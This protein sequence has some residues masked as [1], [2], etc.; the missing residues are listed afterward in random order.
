MAKDLLLE[1]GTEELP[2]AFVPPALADLESGTR[3]ALEDARLSHG[4]LHVYGTPRRLAVLVEQLAA[5][6]P[7]LSRQVTGPPARAAF[8]A[9]GKPTKAA[10][11]FARGQGVA[12]ESL[13]VVET[14]KGPY[15]AAQVEE[16]GRGADEILPE[17]LAGV[18]RGLPFRK[19]MRWGSVDVTFARPVHWMCA[20]LGGKGL[21]FTF[22]DVE[23]GKKTRGHRFLAP[24][25]ISLRSPGQYLEKLEA[26]RVLVDPARRREAVLTQAEAAVREMNPAWR[27]RDDPA[28]VDEVTNLVE[29]PVAVLGGFDPSHLEL[30]PEV[31]VSEMRHHQRY[32]SVE[33]AK[34]GRL[35][36]YFVAVSNTPVKDPAVS[37]RGYERVLAARLADARY[38]Y[39]H[40]RKRRLEDRTTDLERVVFQQKLGT[41]AE[42]VE[43]VRALALWLASRLDLDASQPT[44]GRTATLAKADLTTGMVGEFPDLQGTMGRY[45]AAADGEDPKVAL[46]IEEHYLPRNAGD[47]LPEGDEGA[48]VGL[49]DRI[50]TL[51]GIFGIGKPPSGAADPFGLRRAT[52]GAVNIVLARGYRFS[53][54]ALLDQALDLLVPKLTLSAQDTKAAVLDFF[55]GRLKN[56]WAENHPVDVVEAV[57]SA[58]FDDLLGARERVDAL[59]RMKAA[60][61]FAPLAEAFTRAANIVAKAPTV[62]ARDV[63]PDLFEDESERV[64][65]KK[66]MSIH[67][68]VEQAL[69]E[70]DYGAALAEMATLKAPVAAFFD[71]VLV[72]AEEARVRDNRLLLLSG[73]ADL[74]GGI[75]DF[76]KIQTET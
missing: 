3:T 19:S 26:A 29:L 28:L 54:S 50:D 14:P 69:A 72:M 5:R 64:L 71:A 48:L 30:P 61:D 1:I 51:V 40:D 15:V 62:E 22:G 13:E 45:Y 20:L 7:D 68:K 67:E 65:W 56:L 9:E 2:A 41:V 4:A 42:K 43:R 60:P 59:S 57:L 33:D 49:A 11:G 24:A 37:R 66:G 63:E 46:G 31:L 8:D 70:H 55:R 18:V 38:F 16:K 34:T 52:L 35:V 75:A 27:L 36:P 25:E 58:G 39:E 44:I 53:L 23:S 17:L 21:S 47:R 6:Q 10:E 12:V 74:F 32:F 76:S 73:I